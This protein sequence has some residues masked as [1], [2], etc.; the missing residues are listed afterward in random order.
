MSQFPDPSDEALGR[1]LSA[2]LPR[3]TAPSG[4]RHRLTPAAV[5]ERRRPWWLAPAFAAAAT[6]L[7]LSL[8]FVPMLPRIV[9]ADPA[10]RLVRAV[11]AEHTRV[12]LWGARRPDIVP[13]SIPWLT[14]ETGIDLSSVF[15]GD[16]R[17]ELQGAE[18]VYLDQRRGVAVHYKDGEGHLVTYIVLPAP[19]LTVPE[20]ERVKIDRFRPALVHDNSH[21]VWLWKQGELACFLVADMVSDEELA[22]FKEYFVRVRSAT[23]PVRAY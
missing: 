10:Q 19:G 4:L 12:V 23:E 3:Y 18:P 2:E 11:V 17:L 13:A 20:R 8:F 9:P 5:P 16:D 22:Q 15:V 14:Q 7:M 21:A 1:R 6:A